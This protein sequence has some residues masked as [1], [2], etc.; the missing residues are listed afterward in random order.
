MPGLIPNINEGGEHNGDPIRNPELE[1]REQT[2]AKK[3]ET[4]F[5]DLMIFADQN[6]LVDG[7]W[8]E[9]P[10]NFKYKYTSISLR[11]TDGRAQ[12]GA[13]TPLG[14]EY[15]WRVEDEEVLVTTFPKDAGV[16]RRRA[17]TRSLSEKE[18]MTDL[19]VP[20]SGFEVTD[21]L[22]EEDAAEVFR[23]ELIWPPSESESDS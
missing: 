10:L 2:L 6:E 14:N 18:F 4:L 17:Y 3:F 5:S 15:V 12:I 22:R 1:D 16:L 11:L 7:V 13:V 9:L 19:V 23:G 21:E 20:I 8:Q